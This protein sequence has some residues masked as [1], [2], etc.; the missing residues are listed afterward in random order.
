MAEGD[1]SSGMG[2]MMG[3]MS[4]GELLM[5][6]GAAWILVV[7][8]VIGNRIASDFGNSMLV[9]ASLLSL[10][11]LGSGYAANSGKGGGLGSVYPMGS[12]GGHL[13][14]IHTRCSRSP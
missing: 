2:G 5:S 12:R 3:K 10:L 7:V 4:T 6:L 9:T 11:V 8:Y 1:G 14:D 13:G